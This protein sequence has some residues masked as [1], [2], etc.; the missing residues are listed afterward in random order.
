MLSCE[1]AEED[2]RRIR[3]VTWKK[4]TDGNWLFKAQDRY[5]AL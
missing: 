5:L 2:C 3:V 4:T 1:R